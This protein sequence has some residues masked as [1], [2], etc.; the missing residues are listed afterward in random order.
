MN[1]NKNISI[2]E[3]ATTFRIVQTFRDKKGK[4]SEEKNN[5]KNTYDNNEGNYIIKPDEILINRYK[6]IKSIGKGTFANCF[7]VMIVKIRKMSV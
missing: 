7:Y 3:E 2:T 1:K 5:E 4:I 6:V